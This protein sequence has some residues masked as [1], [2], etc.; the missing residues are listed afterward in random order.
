MLQTAKQNCE[1][2]LNYNKIAFYDYDKLY[3]SFYEYLPGQRKENLF[4]ADLEVILSKE[5]S[6]FEHE[7]HQDKMKAANN[8][9]LDPEGS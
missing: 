7:M 6:R 5:L 2:I 4:N 1:N 8:G 3:K 9:L